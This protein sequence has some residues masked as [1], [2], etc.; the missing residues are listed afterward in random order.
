MWFHDK[1]VVVVNKGWDKKQLR[2]DYWFKQACLCHGFVILKVS[3]HHCVFCLTIITEGTQS[4]TGSCEWGPGY[5]H[6]TDAG[7]L[8]NTDVE[9][10]EHRA[11]EEEE[12]KRN[13]GREL[14]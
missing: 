12:T 9:P 1:A 2:T 11:Q 13:K 6:E 7:L 8:S 10:Q 4:D 14:G 5:R 3:V